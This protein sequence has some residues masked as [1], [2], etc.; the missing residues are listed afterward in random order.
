MEWQGNNHHGQGIIG[1]LTYIQRGNKSIK[2]KKQPPESGKKDPFA[3]KTPGAR[4]QPFFFRPLLPI[5][6]GVGRTGARLYLSFPNEI[7]GSGGAGIGCF[8][9]LRIPSPGS[10]LFKKI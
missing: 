5:R 1:Y 2:T 8:P 3:A 9:L 10:F 7:G 4:V 6:E